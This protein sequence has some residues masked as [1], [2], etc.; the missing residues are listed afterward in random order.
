VEV[1]VQIFFEDI[2]SIED[3]MVH[4]YVDIDES[5]MLDFLSEEEEPISTSISGISQFLRLLQ[6]AIRKAR[7]RDDAL[8]IRLLLLLNPTYKSSVHSVLGSHS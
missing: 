8:A 2:P 4:Y 1:Q 6:V 7:I 3:G 5:S